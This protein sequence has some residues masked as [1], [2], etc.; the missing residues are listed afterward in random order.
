MGRILA[1]DYG[2]KR[3]GIAVTDP[4]QIIATPLEMVPTSE[5]LIFLKKYLQKE[6][7]ESVVIG[8]PKNLQNEDTDSTEG[9]R[10]FIAFL[11]REFPEMVIH[12]V[13]ER[14]TSKM[15]LQSMI[16]AGSKKK[17]RREKG[18]IDKISATLILQSYLES[19]A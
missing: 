10:K 18:N 9:V 5:L 7:V 13:D 12:T 15:A 16:A 8:M 4:L 6:S 3:T 2:K 17:D 19:R 14:F 11:N 1:I